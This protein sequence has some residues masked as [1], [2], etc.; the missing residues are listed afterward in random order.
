MQIK[1][2]DYLLLKIISLVKQTNFQY[3][4]LVLFTERKVSNLIEQ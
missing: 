4:G 2:W 1:M 3:I